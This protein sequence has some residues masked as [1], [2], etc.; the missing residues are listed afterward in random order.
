M[1]FGQ[2]QL[3]DALD[4]GGRGIRQMPTVGGFCRRLDVVFNAAFLAETVAKSLL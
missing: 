2:R 1:Q 4:D 3:D